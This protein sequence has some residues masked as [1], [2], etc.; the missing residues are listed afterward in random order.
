MAVDAR[1][2]TAPARLLLALVPFATRPAASVDEHRSADEVL[3]AIAA[4]IE[5]QG[6]VPNFGD[7]EADLKSEA[8]SG[9]VRVAERR[10]ELSGLMMGV[11]PANETLLLKSQEKAEM[12]PERLLPAA[13]V[14]HGAAGSQPAQSRSVDYLGNSDLV[15]S[16]PDRVGV[17]PPLLP[18]PAHLPSLTTALSRRRSLFG[19]VA[20]DE[21]DTTA[22][23]RAIHARRE[24]HRALEWG[25][26]LLD[27]L[28]LGPA[29]LDE[30]DHAIRA[31]D[32]LDAPDEDL[33][34]YLAGTPSPLGLDVECDSEEY[35]GT[36]LESF[37]RGFVRAGADDAEDD[38]PLEDD[39]PAERDDH[40][41]TEDEAYPWRFET[42]DAVQRAAWLCE[43]ARH[44]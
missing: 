9:A 33:E 10:T 31:L 41:G 13:D 2:T 40:H 17:A 21:P 42:P 28:D 19:A 35:E 23:A 25:F 16:Y 15:P 30:I 1:S 27:A 32:A 37:G 29:A 3:A 20:V 14:L 34:P 26:A 4:E 44:V 8:T 12:P 5:S 24:L 43:V 36:A 7:T 38:D 18:A 39:D 22:E 6:G 11:V